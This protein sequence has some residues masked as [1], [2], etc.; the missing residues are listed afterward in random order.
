MFQQGEEDLAQSLGIQD[1]SVTNT[2]IMSIKNLNPL[3]M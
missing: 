2:I 1:Y 3:S